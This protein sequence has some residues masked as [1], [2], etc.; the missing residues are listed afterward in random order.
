MEKDAAP[1]EAE[2]T[3]GG[4]GASMCPHTKRGADPAACAADATQESSELTTLR[5]RAERHPDATA[6]SATPIMLSR[7][8]AYSN[9]LIW[10]PPQ[11]TSAERTDSDSHLPADEKIR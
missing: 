5:S 10:S 7:S 4:C 11:K 1:P 9:S 6:S 3:T 2:K 8:S